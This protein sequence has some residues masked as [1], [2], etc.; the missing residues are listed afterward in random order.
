[1]KG[2]YLLAAGFLLFTVLLGLLRVVRGPRPA[3]RMIAA[4]LFG[5]TG[6]AI[7]LLLGAAA[8]Q[9]AAA[10]IAL[11]FALFAALATAAFVRCGYR[12]PLPDETGEGETGPPG[13]GTTG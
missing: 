3:D 11:I 13:P 4:Q 9:P 6:I 1:M 8:G 2:F 5:T 10:D 7:V 12:R